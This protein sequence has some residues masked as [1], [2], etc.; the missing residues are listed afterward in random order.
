MPLSKNSV[1]LQYVD[2]KYCG[3]RYLEMYNTYFG[4]ALDDFVGVGELSSD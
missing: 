2:S 1:E 3:R 4:Y